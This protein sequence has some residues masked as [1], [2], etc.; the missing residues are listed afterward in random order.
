MIN[1]EKLKFKKQVSIIQDS[2]FN[3]TE[4]YVYYS[5]TPF[6]IKDY[7]NMIEL[8]NSEIDPITID[9][10]KYDFEFLGIEKKYENE[11]GTT[12]EV[13]FVNK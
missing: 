10:V 5:I 4:I 11:D 12:Y 6:T 3:D 2:W 1:Q 7:R 9:G 13:S 8:T